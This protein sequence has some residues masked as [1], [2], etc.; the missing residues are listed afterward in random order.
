MNDNNEMTQV[1][2]LSE[3]DFNIVNQKTLQLAII[4]ML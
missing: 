2:V 3:N 1:L 4:N